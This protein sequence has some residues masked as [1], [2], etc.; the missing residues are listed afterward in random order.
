MLFSKAVSP[1]IQ[2]KGGKFATPSPS[3]CISHKTRYLSKPKK[4]P[5]P[6]LPGMVHCGLPPAKYKL[7]CGGVA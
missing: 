4:I 5:V 3:P 7:C 2:E 1:I 6:V